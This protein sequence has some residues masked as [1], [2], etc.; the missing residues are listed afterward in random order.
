MISIEKARDKLADYNVLLK[1]MSFLQSNGFSDCG[2][3]QI[4][5]QIALLQEYLIEECG[6]VQKQDREIVKE[7]IDRQEKQMVADITYEAV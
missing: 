5:G 2:R 6:D 1:H 4:L 3:G 7:I